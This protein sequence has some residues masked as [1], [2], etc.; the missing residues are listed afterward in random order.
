MFYLLIILDSIVFKQSISIDTA[1]L[2]E[3]LRMSNLWLGPLQ[4]VGA[5]ALGVVLLSKKDKLSRQM[6]RAG[7]LICCRNRLFVRVINA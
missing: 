3:K 2:V 1:Q 4:G 5:S 7:G 6:R